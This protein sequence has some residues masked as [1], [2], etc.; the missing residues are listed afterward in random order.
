MLTA[1]C[2]GMLAGL[3]NGLLHTKLKIP[4]LLSG[5]LTM[6]ALFSINLRTMA[7]PTSPLRME[8][9]TARSRGSSPWTRASR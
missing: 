5:I 8:T 6:T 3:V 9:C 1:L 2:C 7:G 4:S